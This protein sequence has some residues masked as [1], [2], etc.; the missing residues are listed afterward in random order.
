[1]SLSCTI[2]AVYICIIW[3]VTLISLCWS[4]RAQGIPLGVVASL[5]L[6][7]FVCGPWKQSTFEGPMAAWVMWSINPSWAC[8]MKRAVSKHRRC[9]CLI[10]RTRWTRFARP[11]QVSACEQLFRISD[12]EWYGLVE[13]HLPF[14]LH[15]RLGL[16]SPGFPMRKLPL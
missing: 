10:R 16:S 8:A 2:I 12:D 13:K 7:N 3:L 15:L 5:L 11:S 6:E 9:T 4:L 14:Q 1:M